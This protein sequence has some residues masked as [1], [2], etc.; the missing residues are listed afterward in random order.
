MRLKARHGPSGCPTTDCSGGRA[1]R[2]SPMTEAQLDKL[3]GTERALAGDNQGR[4][5]RC[6]YCGAVYIPGEVPQVL[7]FLDSGVLGEGWD[8][9]SQRY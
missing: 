1:S 2:Q 9:R 7:G 3:T 4:V 6:T 8:P 5:K